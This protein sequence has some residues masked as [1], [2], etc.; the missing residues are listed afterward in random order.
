[1]I[2]QRVHTMC[3][4]KVGT[5]TSSGHGS[6][7]QLQLQQQLQQS[8]SSTPSNVFS[9]SFSGF[10]EIGSLSGPTGAILS[11]GQGQLTLNVDPGNQFVNFQLTYSGL[12]SNVTQA[13]IHF[14][15][16]HVTGG[17]MGFSA[18]TGPLL[19]RRPALQKH[20]AGWQDLGPESCS[21]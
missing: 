10:E 19:L 2:P 17:I 16:E 13:H 12:S 9:A 14:G 21:A 11:N 7:L 3:G 6:Q 18:R 5:G 1:M 4:P 20:D 15:K 8:S